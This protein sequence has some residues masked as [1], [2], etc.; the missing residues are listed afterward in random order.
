LPIDS[1]GSGLSEAHAAALSRLSSILPPG[2]FSWEHKAVRFGP[3]C[4]VLRAGDLTLEVLPKVSTKFGGDG[5]TRGVLIAMLR[6]AGE[7]SAMPVGTAPLG[8]QR[9]HLLDVFIIDFCNRVNE[10]L[11]RGAIRAYETREENLVAARGRIHM[12]EHVRRNW[13]DRSRIFCRYDEF[14]ADNPHNQALKAVLTRLLSHAACAEAK[15]AVNSLLRRLAD[16]SSRPCSV[17][18]LANLTF[19]RFTR[20]WQSVFERMAQFL[21][22]SVSG[23]TRWKD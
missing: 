11:R 22:G 18:S 4:G 8:L 5:E 7:L 10:L 16:V 13:F 20:P 12:T 1:S 14:S 21:G 6:S 17:A 9:L 15:G 3:Y 2:V 23:R 19:D